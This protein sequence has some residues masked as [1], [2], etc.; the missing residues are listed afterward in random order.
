[1]AERFSR[2][3][4][5]P[6]NLYTPGSPLVIAAGAL[7]LDNQSGSVVAQ[8][9]LRSISDKV[10]KAVRVAVTGLD[11]QDQ[12]RCREEFSYEGLNAARDS[13]F[14]AKQAIR[15]S[16]AAVRSF[17]VQLL[18]VSFADSSSYTGEA[19]KW[20]SL[21]KQADLNL[22]LFDAELIRQ[23]Q[24]ETGKDSRFVPVEV[25]DLWLCACGEIN[26]RGESCHRCEQSFE[27]CKKYLNVELL[28][29]NKSLRL[30]GEAVQAALNEEKR[31]GRARVFQRILY[32]LLPVLLI[33]GIA[34]GVYKLSE[35]RELMYAEATRLYD[36]GEYADAALI[37]DKLRHFRD[38][39]DMADKAKKADAQV[40]SYQRAG[41]LMQNERWDDAYEA[42]KE[43][44][45]F[46]DSE[47]LAR[48]A[49]YQKGLSLLREENYGEAQ[50][51]FLELG[52][53]K[54]CAAVSEHF[55]PRRLSEEVSLNQEAG[56]PLTTTYRY[57]TLGRVSEKT[58]HFSEYE[59][60]SDRV[61]VYQYNADGS[62]SVTEGQ[63]EKRYDAYGAYIGQ[64]DL[65]SYVYEYEFYADGTVH[66][67]MDYDALNHQYRGSAAY[68]E[69]GNLVGVQG[70]DGAAYTLL[71]DYDGDLL[72]KQERYNEDGNM[73]SRVS[74]EYDADGLLK[75]A[76]FLTPGG[77]ATVTT[78]YENGPIF[79]MK[80]EE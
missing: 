48:E 6:E 78:L 55:F 27:N 66:F 30:N 13:L 76:T 75:R 44:G 56:G 29:E 4:S 80:L 20:R 3:F 14:G 7:L 10:I 52:Q 18:A 34:F 24:L 23:Y 31:Q 53:Y 60:M 39:S 12:E 25:Q 73:V 58:E 41:K 59:G 49:R 11:G 61:Y 74:F 28:R 72:M 43:L 35:R 15:M 51:I 36:S 50:P 79:A 17:T 42:Y 45:S 70:E 1:M 62:Y 9:K 19:A 77:G 68:D 46:E 22:R 67:R 57:D 5:L 8:L 32:V 26:H 2:L 40:A 21:P 16:D 47:E 64:G 54:D 38:S 63:V 33:A 37:F 69:H 71:N 65:V